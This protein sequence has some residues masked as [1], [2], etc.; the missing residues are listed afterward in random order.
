MSVSIA[1][2]SFARLVSDVV[3]LGLGF[4]SGV[5]TA[6][7][8]GPG[9]K[10]A[11]AAL[12]SLLTVFGS[13]STLGLGDALVI[14]VGRREASMGRAMGAFLPPVFLASV[15]GGFGLKLIAELQLSDRGP[16][17]GQSVLVASLAVPTVALLKMGSA[18]LNSKEQIV[19]LSLIRGLAQ[20]IGLLAMIAFVIVVP[21]HV[22]GGVFAQALASLFGAAAVFVWLRRQGLVRLAWE[23]ALLRRALA[24][25]LV[26][27]VAHT[28]LAMASRIDV[29][30]V[31]SLGGRAEA[32]QYSVALTT[33]QLVA[34]TSIAIS[35]AT[36]PR[37]AKLA[38]EDSLPLIAQAS[39]LGLAT[40]LI[41]GLFLLVVIPVGIPLAFGDKYAPAV[42]P[43]LIL[44]AGSALWAEQSLLVRGRTA[45]GRARL[46]LAA[47]GLTLCVM[48]LLDFILI[49]LWGIVG[50][51]LASV[52]APAA[53]LAFCALSYRSEARRAGL[54]V[55]DFVPGRDDLKLLF[56]F[57]RGIVRGGSSA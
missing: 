24:L 34:F 30:F 52:I 43:A 1:K 54:K 57:L 46:E 31:Y 33:A 3:F 11:Y 32:G 51:A 20:A 40:S 21:L 2:N 7:W 4:A 45:R 16:T 9:G 36:F 13:I 10:G 8:L 26:I 19:S 38:S 49:P 14:I 5:I 28:M 53:G 25:G 27:E 35:Y 55:T 48:L 23:P 47:Y 41:S 6:R 50:A 39:R 15:L 17:L 37:L 29:L 22:T 42:S 44:L 56:D 18:A 12:I